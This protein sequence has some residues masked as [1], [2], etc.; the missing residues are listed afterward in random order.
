MRTWLAILG[1]AS[2]RRGHEWTTSEWSSRAEGD[3]WHFAGFAFQRKI[4]S[5]G[6]IGIAVPHQDSSE[7][8]VISEP[9]SHHVEYLAFVPIRTFPYVRQRRHLQAVFRNFCFQ[10]EMN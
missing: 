5:Q 6:K 8:R 3:V 9:D 4:L 10:T 2:S 1:A 7:I